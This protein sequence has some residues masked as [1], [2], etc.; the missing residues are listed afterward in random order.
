MSVRQHFIRYAPGISLLSERRELCM[1]YANEP[2][3]SAG[4]WITWERERERERETRRSEQRILAQY[5]T[6]DP[7]D[8]NLNMTLKTGTE[9]C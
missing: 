4:A 5:R 6:I 1:M 8:N 9:S 7:S 3:I 2:A